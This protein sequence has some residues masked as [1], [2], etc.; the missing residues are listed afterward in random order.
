[1]CVSVHRYEKVDA[2]VKHRLKFF[3]HPDLDAFRKEELERRFAK[4]VTEKPKESRAGKLIHWDS[5]RK[6]D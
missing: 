2:D 1:M 4:V 6:S 5:K 3:M